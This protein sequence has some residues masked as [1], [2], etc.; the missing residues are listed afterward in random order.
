MAGMH[1]VSL[2]RQT[3]RH[4]A[5]YSVANVLGRLVSFLMLPFYAHIFKAEGYGVIALIDASIGFLSVAFAS[6]S[7]NAIMKVY[8]EEP[9]SRKPLVI[10]TGIWIVWGLSLLCI[11]LP[12]LISPWI[13]VL[14]LGD[15]AYW[16]LIVLALITFVVDMGG[17]SA[18]T[19]LVI[20]QRSALYSAVNLLRLI[21]GLTLNIVLVVYLQI[22]LIGIF[23]SSLVSASAASLIFHWVAIREHGLCYDPKIGQ[24]LRE[25]WFPL[26]PGEL[27]SYAS[28]Q[29]ER[30]LVRFL[31]SLEGVGILEMAYKFPP[32]LNLFIVHP[33]MR[34]WGTKS[35][36]IGPQ[37]DAPK[38]IGSIFTLYIF[39]TLFGAVF[40]AANIG[41]VLK[42][43]TPPEFWPAVSIARIDIATTVMAAANAYLV[44][45]LLYS[46]QTHTITQ[47]RMIAAVIKIGLSA[48]F[49]LVAGLAGAAYSALVME[50]IV[51]IWIFNKAQHAY[52]L[53]LEYRKIIVLGGFA[54]MLVVF[55]DY[56]PEFASELLNWIELVVFDNLI[57][58]LS[59]TPLAA[60][61]SGKLIETLSNRTTQFAHLLVSC[62]LCMFYGLLIFVVKPELLGRFY[63]IHIL[64]P[65]IQTIRRKAE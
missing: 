51:L 36:E 27:F 15:N 44:F 5:V 40:M 12:V 9:E 24:K 55:V 20:R 62:C 43:M 48:I 31:I 58:F 23:I 57:A 2:R 39:L 10:S 8:H 33:F 63:K 26:I 65:A 42:I 38:E 11:P 50:V 16:F 21:L 41:S 60:W 7:Y 49:I 19:F 22:G 45:G 30:F 56:V 54:I 6:G 34:A 46:K 13:S 25:F 29:A 53:V 32:L 17:Q 35:L 14:V 64:R 3:L 4:L 1:R 37:P 18:S 61:R 47:I 52:R 59:N 28:R